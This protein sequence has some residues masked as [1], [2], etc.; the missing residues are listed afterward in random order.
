[1]LT[2]P[3]D[4]PSTPLSFSLGG[5]DALAFSIDSGTGKV[6]LTGNPDFE[7]QASYSFTV[8]AT[9][10]ASN[11]SAAKAVSL[12][13]NNLDEVAPVV[14]S[15][16]TAAAINENSGAGQVVYTATATDLPDLTHPSDG[17][18]TPLSFSL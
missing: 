17:P 10:T 15:G 1:D 12:A 14:T 16:A 8:T 18:S 11:A 7:G 2:H 3:S 9:D 6:T 4:G 5:P 13:I